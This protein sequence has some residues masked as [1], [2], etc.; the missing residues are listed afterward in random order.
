MHAVDVNAVRIV[1][2]CK[3]YWREYANVSYG[4]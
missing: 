4:L 3:A 2:K 1:Y